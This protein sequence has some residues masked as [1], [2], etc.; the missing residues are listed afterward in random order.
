MF[1]CPALE[2]NALLY[3]PSVLEFNAS[4]P[5]AELAVPVVLLCNDKCPTTELDNI[6]PPPIPTV[7]P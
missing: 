3:S 1:A 5:N 6:F 7:I 4:N 2:P